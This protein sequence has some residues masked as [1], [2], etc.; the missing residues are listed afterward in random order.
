MQKRVSS[1]AGI[2][3]AAVFDIVVEDL[4][5]QSNESSNSKVTTEYL[6][7]KQHDKNCRT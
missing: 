3:G 2:A 1:A 6:D 4:K 5:H 7:K